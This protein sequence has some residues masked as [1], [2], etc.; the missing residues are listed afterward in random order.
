MLWHMPSPPLAAAAVRAV[1]ERAFADVPYPGDDN[2]CTFTYDDEGVADY[3]RGRPWIGHRAEDLRLHDFALCVL[4]DAALHYYLPAFILTVLDDRDAADVL[5]Q[6]VVR[7]LGSPWWRTG[8]LL[9]RLSATQRDAVRAFLEFEF[10]TKRAESAEAGSNEVPFAGEEE[11]WRALE[12]LA[13]APPPADMRS[14]TSS[15]EGRAEIEGV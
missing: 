10:E 4:T 6:G 7:V 11:L 12:M 1:I 9:A 3:F 14:H 13:D 2:L 8:N 15:R 5:V